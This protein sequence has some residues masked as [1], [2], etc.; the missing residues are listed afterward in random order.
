M[1]F[2]YLSYGLAYA[3]P[4]RA[5]HIHLRKCV[6]CCCWAEY[7]ID[8]RSIEFWVLLKSSISSLVLCLVVLS[9]IDSGALSFQL[10]SLNIL[11]L[12]LILYIF[13][14]FLLH[15]F[16]YSLIRCTYVDNFYVFLMS[17]PFSHDKISLFLSDNIFLCFKIYFFVLV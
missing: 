8:V 14:I 17:W 13:G 6:S 12:L 15:A 16:W 7:C 2:N 1:D 5:F 3:L 4:W 11:F 9:I 10:I